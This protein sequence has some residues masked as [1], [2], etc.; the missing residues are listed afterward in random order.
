MPVQEQQGTSYHDEEQDRVPATRPGF[1]GEKGL[2]L[3]GE[4]IRGV[5]QLLLSW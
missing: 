4:F 5:V 2:N 1:R 3:E